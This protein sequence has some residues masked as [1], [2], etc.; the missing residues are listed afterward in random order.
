MKQPDEIAGSQTQ[1]IYIVVTD[2]DATMPEPSLAGPRSQW[3]SRT[4]IM[5]VGL[6]VATILKAISGSFGTYD[7]WVRP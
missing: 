7:P 4:R 6:S 5:A 1:T 3:R 2:A